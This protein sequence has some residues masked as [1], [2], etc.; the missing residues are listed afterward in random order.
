[1]VL[2]KKSRKKE[3]KGYDMGIATLFYMRKSV[4]ICDKFLIYLL[5]K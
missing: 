3:N 4:A 5:G 1:M 2:Q